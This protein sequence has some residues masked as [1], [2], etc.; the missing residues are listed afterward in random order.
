[1]DIYKKGTTGSE[2]GLHPDFGSGVWDGQP[3]GIPYNIV[4][5]IRKK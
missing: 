4:G 1:V 5:R 3:I 2:K